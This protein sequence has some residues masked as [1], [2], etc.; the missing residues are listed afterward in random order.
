MSVRT[1]TPEDIYDLMPLVKKFWREGNYQ[2]LHYDSEYIS[3]MYRSH[4][5]NPNMEVFLWETDGEVKGMLIACKMPQAFSTK[6]AAY[7]IAWYVSPEARGGSAA[8]RLL[9]AY[10]T[11]A[12]EQG[13]DFMNMSRIE[14]VEDEKVHAMYSKSGLKVREHTYVKEFN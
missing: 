11:W 6:P 2:N 8:M 3:Q 4:L 5:E 13:C 12:K 14:G 7:E 10:E 1:A 9:K